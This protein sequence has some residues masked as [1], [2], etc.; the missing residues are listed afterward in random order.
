MAAL[1]SLSFVALFASLIALETETITQNQTTHQNA[2][3]HHLQ[4]AFS[5]SSHQFLAARR[6]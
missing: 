3:P 4:A 1:A 5:G 6:R 2:P